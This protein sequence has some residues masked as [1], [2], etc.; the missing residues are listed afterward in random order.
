MAGVLLEA[1]RFDEVQATL[2]IM[3]QLLD[4]FAGPGPGAFHIRISEALLS[5]YR[6]ELAKAA[7]ML[8]ALQIEERQRGNLQ[9]IQPKRVT[10]PSQHGARDQEGD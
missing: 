8:K 5:R 9:H 10:V 2:P 6:G 4:N 1:G 3:R 7:Q